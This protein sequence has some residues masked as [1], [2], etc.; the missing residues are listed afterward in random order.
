MTPLSRASKLPSLFSAL[1]SDLDYALDVAVCLIFLSVVS[2][3]R[4]KAGKL[5]FYGFEAFT[6]F[7]QILDVR[8]L[9]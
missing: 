2:I 8:V 5:E 9:N 6:N 4:A 1:D 7:M 3:C